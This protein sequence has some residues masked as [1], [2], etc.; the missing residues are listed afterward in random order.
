MFDVEHLQMSEMPQTF[1]PCV[2]DRQTGRT[3]VLQVL[4]GADFHH[5]LITKTESVDP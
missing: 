3:Q 4:S 2:G 1:E 5:Q